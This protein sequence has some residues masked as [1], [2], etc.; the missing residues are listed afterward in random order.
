MRRREFITLIAGAAAGRSL[1]ARAQ[2][3][4]MPVI[5][6]LNAG[7]AVQWAHLV[8]AFRKG[9]REVGYTEGQNVVIEYRWAESHYDWLPAMAADLVRRRVTVIASG[10][11]DAPAQ[12]AKGAT[13]TIPIVFTSGDDPVKFG[14]VKSFNRPDGN[15]TGVSS[16]S[17]LTGSKRLGVL[18]ELV[19]PI[20]VAVLVDRA[21]PSSQIEMEDLHSTAKI[22]NQRLLELSVTSAA[23]IGSAFDTI[24][25]STPTAWSSQ[26]VL[27]LPANVRKSLSRQHAMSFQRFT[28]SVN[29]P[30]SAG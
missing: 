17:Q 1:S 15:I 7:S 28:P 2:Q 29:L 4:A 10:G 20:T 9:L 14:L 11:G 16:F 8:A 21:R 13:T 22:Y 18:R 27:C 5:G 25:S 23:D 24:G 19:H 26:V 30:T 3:P 6:F 12:A